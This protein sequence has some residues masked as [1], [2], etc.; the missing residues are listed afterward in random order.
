[1][2][3]YETDPLFPWSRLDDSP[4]LQTIRDFFRQLPDGKLLADL[5][6]QRGRGRNDYPVRS[7]WF[8]ALLQPL[9]RHPSMQLT[10]EELGRNADLRRL[11]GMESVAEV[12]KP[13]NMSRF[14][15]LL[16]QEPYRTMLTEVFDKMVRRLGE[17]VPDLGRDV[18]GDST[19]LKARKSR[20]RAGRGEMQP[21]GG[22]KE[23]TDKAGD[24]VR[25][26]EWFGYKLHIICDTRHE[27]ALSY[28]VTPAST[29]DNQPLPEL[30][31]AARGNLPQGRIETLAY[32]KAADDAGTH[33]M[34]AE[35]GI[36][37]LIETRSLWK[38]EQER[39]LEHAGIGNI[40]Y[41]EAGT[42]YCYDMASNPPVRHE[43]AYIG[44]EAKRGT[45]KYRCPAMHQGW[46]CPCHG[47]CNQGKSYGLT[48]RVRQSLD[49]RRFPPIPRATQTFEKLY[50]GRTAV[51][52]V[53]ARLKVFWG[54]DDG[55]V[56][57]GAGFL[58]SVGIVMVAH[59]GLATLLA[60]APRRAGP[61]L[62]ACGAPHSTASLRPEPLAPPS[63]SPR[64]RAQRN[65]L[66][67]M[68]P[69]ARR[70]AWRPRRRSSA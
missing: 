11:G 69:P 27:V 5:H 42:V 3:L 68:R 6:E 20:S 64:S 61:L 16:G 39:S 24:C 55:N 38:D 22:R 17:A 30:V 62:Q 37:P 18:S 49:L 12:P 58:A 29:H 14:L 67:P 54:V 59:I 41:D 31:K 2:I 13:W 52:R 56:A 23:Y 63:R 35:A 70:H 44:H 34:L 65:R 33:A 57:G 10:L 36:K 4:D 8:C 32:D 25:I 60:G 21:D 53:H 19:H 40:V 9:L 50:K 66:R 48:V 7:L 26:L 47:R 15:A 1:M 45:L 28:R 46:K 43:M 51:E